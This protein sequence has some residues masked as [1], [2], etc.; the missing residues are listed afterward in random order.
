MLQIVSRTG[1][2]LAYNGLPATIYNTQY[3]AFDTQIKF[4]QVVKMNGKRSLLM[5]FEGPKVTKMCF[6][7]F[8]GEFRCPFIFSPSFIV[9]FIQDTTNSTEQFRG[10][11]TVGWNYRRKRLNTV[12]KRP[13]VSI[14]F[15]P[16]PQFFHNFVSFHPI[17][18]FLTILESG[19]KT[20]NIGDE[21]KTIRLIL[22]IT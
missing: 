1:R 19:D 8:F 7:M 2:F 6:L 12:R 3:L 14:I 21:F 22:I 20:N 15:R 13:T 10:I 16:S 18:M 9:I 4:E 11:Y 5:Y 17:L